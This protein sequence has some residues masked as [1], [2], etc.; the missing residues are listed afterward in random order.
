MDLDRPPVDDRGDE[1]ALDEVRHRDEG[2]QDD[3]GVRSDGGE[4]DD[5]FEF[6]QNSLL[7]TTWLLGGDGTDTLDF[8]T[9]TA[10]VTVD[11][12]NVGA[13]QIALAAELTLR[14]INEDVEIVIGGSGS[15]D[16][17]RT[18]PSGLWLG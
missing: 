5:R 12:S 14:L 9:F 6:A 11:L 7:E 16:G 1:V 10:G 2:E 8:S 17:L 3:D 13:N 18:R 15:T 4:G